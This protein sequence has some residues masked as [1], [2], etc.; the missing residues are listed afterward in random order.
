MSDK[1]IS[2]IVPVYNTADYLPRCLN[3]IKD[4]TYGNLEVLLI[5]D[6]S[7]DS[8]A[9]IC[10]T[11]AAADKRFRLI[12]RENGGS[13]RARNTGLDEA[14]GEYIGFIDSDDYI[15]PE[16]YEK[17]A[18]VLDNHRDVDFAQILAT[19]EAEDGSEVKSVR[20]EE[21]EKDKKSL[22]SFGD[23]KQFFRDLLLHTGD[24]SLCTKLIRREVIGTRRLPEGRLN[25]DFD[26]LLK[27]AVDIRKY[28]TVKYEGYR[29][30]QRSGSNTRRSFNAEFYRVV[31]ENTKLAD[32]YRKKYFPDL[33]RE[34]RHFYMV[35]AMWLLLHIPTDLMTKDNE[36][37]A[38]TMS[39]LRGM[40]K[41]ILT[42]PYLRKEHRRNLMILTFLPAKT[43]KKLHEALKRRGRK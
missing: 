32:E 2:V 7:T 8:S 4:Q 1:L 24:S 33:E 31:M 30:I 41:E 13:S 17:L 38:G 5:D 36:L 39:E 25:E 27:L 23:S 22:Y 6:G 34:S 29:I 9:E 12:S 20:N 16:M 18:W 28:S 10:R 43:I 14:K 37:Y 15:E 11:Y 3:S 35:Q 42:N 40:K 21:T 26:F 19:E